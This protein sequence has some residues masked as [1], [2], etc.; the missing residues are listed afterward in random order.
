M[1]KTGVSGCWN[2]FQSIGSGT[3]YVTIQN[4]A[5]T[6][7]HIILSINDGTSWNGLEEVKLENLSTTEWG[8]YT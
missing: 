5:G 1:A 6:I 2:D 4:K 8:T 3:C 7:E